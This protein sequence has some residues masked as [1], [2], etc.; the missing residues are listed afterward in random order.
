MTQQIKGNYLKNLK[1]I[2]YWLFQGVSATPN[3]W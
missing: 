3:L 1:K 2:D